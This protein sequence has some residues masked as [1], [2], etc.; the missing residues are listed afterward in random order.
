MIII[1]LLFFFLFIWV[2]QIRRMTVATV[3]VVF[4]L[5]FLVPISSMATSEFIPARKVVNGVV[6]CALLIFGT[7][8]IKYKN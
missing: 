4:R 7:A 5:L 8:E 3:P 2:A 6:K 1:F